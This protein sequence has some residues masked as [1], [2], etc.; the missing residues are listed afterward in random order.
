MACDRPK[1]QLL[2]D[3]QLGLPLYPAKTHNLV[4]QDLIKAAWDPFLQHLPVFWT[5]QQT[6]REQSKQALACMYL[7]V[8]SALKPLFSLF[9]LQPLQ[10]P[11]CKEQFSAVT[12]PWSG[13]GWQILSAAQPSALYAS[14]NAVQK[15]RFSILW[16][17]IASF[18]STCFYLFRIKA[19]GSPLLPS[20]AQTT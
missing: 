18:W 14:Q 6:R 5:Y 7:H 2:H 13:G 10:N 4:D 20:S 12:V 19:K 15:R 3:S 9:S 16:F 1:Q 17:P 8:A 11:K